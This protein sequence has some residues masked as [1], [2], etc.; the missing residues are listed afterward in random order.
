MGV[1][2][3][4]KSKSGAVLSGIKSGLLCG[5]VTVMLSG[6]SIPAFAQDSQAGQP[7]NASGGV[8]YTRLLEQEAAGT[9]PSRTMLQ[10]PN[11][12]VASSATSPSQAQPEVILPPPSAAQPAETPL[13]IGLQDV[14][15]AGDV[16]SLGIPEGAQV[17]DDPALGLQ[18]RRVESIDNS[19]EPP[20]ISA[21]DSM[22]EEE[23]ERQAFQKLRERAL[24][25][26]QNGMFPLKP[27]EI[28]QMLRLFNTTREVGETAERPIPTPEVRV[29][30]VSL[31]P[32]VPPETIQTSPGYVTSLTVLDVSG[33]P[34]PVQDV[35]W[36]G[37]FEVVPPESQG[38][39]IRITPMSAHGLGNMSIRLVGL[40]T[41]VTFSL[42]TGFDRVHYRFDARMPEYGPN[43][44]IPIIGT[45]MAAGDALLTSVLDGTPPREARRLKVGGVDG[46]TSVWRVGSGIYVRTPFTLLSPGWK[47]SASSADG[48]KVYS[49]GESP[50]LLL[51][52]GGNM[53][54]ASIGKEETVDGE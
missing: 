37:Q 10:A 20:A 4:N 19:M 11:T 30:T 46:R 39:V 40:T 51:S 5:I 54:R 38:H 25:Q 43:A 29:V 16:V 17:S 8:D 33:Q 47:Q 23:K 52:D 14:Q 22:T 18:F 7:L 35:S 28:S 48:M 44:N 45:S 21:E 50:V 2:Q 15:G 12:V 26:V 13:P 32:S 27:E 1:L 36:A 41:P 3:E 49:I 9:M 6:V 31:D 34:W 42:A 53:V 24:D